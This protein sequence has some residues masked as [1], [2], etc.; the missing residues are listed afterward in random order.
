MRAWI[1]W[2]DWAKVLAGAWLF[3]TPWVLSGTTTANWNAWILGAA[4]LVV[5]IWSLAAP[6]S[7]AAEW[8][9]AVFGLWVFL[10]PWVFGT[11]AQTDVSWN[12]WLVGIAVCGL[13]LWALPEASEPRLTTIDSPHRKAQ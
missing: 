10:S 2:K 3:V 12:A 4:I 8:T 6:Q 1:R 13:A 5:A 9:N 11:T 7:T